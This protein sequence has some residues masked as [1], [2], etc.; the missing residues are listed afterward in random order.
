M[1]VEL[2]AEQQAFIQQAIESGRLG[3]AEEAALSLWEERERLEILVAVDRAEASLARGRRNRHH[4]AIDARAR[5]RSEAARTGNSA[6]QFARKANRYPRSAIP[7]C[8]PYRV[9]AIAQVIAN[10]IS[11]ILKLVRAPR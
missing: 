8:A 2:T 10:K 6:R 11:D 4:A 1:K 7:G 5:R 3:S 9:C